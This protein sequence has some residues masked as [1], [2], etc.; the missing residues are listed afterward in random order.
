M[1]RLKLPAGSVHRDSFARPRRRAAQQLSSTEAALAE[2]NGGGGGTPGEGPADCVGTV[3]LAAAMAAV[4]RARRALAACDAD[5]AGA[6][7]TGPVVEANV[8]AAEDAEAGSGP[9][10]ISTPLPSAV[11]IGGG[12]ARVSLLRA[13]P[14]VAVVTP[15]GGGGG[16]GGDVP[17]ALNAPAEYSRVVMAVAPS[18]AAAVGVGAVGPRHGKRHRSLSFAFEET[19]ALRLPRRVFSRPPALGDDVTRVSHSWT[20]AV[21]EKVA[22]CLRAHH[23]CAVRTMEWASTC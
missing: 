6:G 1:G 5:L 10:A 15:R 19:Q 17:R 13:G 8:A 2:A 16:R 3:T 23:F 9:E 11:V 18:L 7:P 12:M 22:A 20:L 4:E 14:S 21:V